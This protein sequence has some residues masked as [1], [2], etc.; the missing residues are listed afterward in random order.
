[1]VGQRLTVASPSRPSPTL[2]SQVSPSPTI[3]IAASPTL[4]A[5]PSSTLSVVPKSIVL[6]VPFTIQAPDGDWSEPWAEGCEEAALLMVEA[7]RQGNHDDRLPVASTKAAI[8]G[9]VDWQI[10]HYGAHQDLPVEKIADLARQSLK[11]RSTRVVVSADLED[12][13]AE[14]RSGNPVI[15]PAAGQLLKNPYFKTPGPPYHVMVVIGYD[16]LGFIVQ[17]NGTRQGFH[18]H[19]PYSTIEMAWHDYRAEGPEVGPRS[20]L[21]LE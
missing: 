17:E 21:V 2:S 4:L 16:P 8:K 9:L 20:Y 7:Y 18:Y 19:Y 15:L 14:L 10:E 6:P 12:L 1:M 5:T 13:K 3:S 11:D